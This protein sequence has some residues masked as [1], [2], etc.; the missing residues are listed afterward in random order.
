[1][2]APISLA[3]PDPSDDE[4]TQK[5][6]EAM[7]PHDVFET[8]EELNHRMEVELNWKPLLINMASCSLE[9]QL[10]TKIIL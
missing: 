7:K 9:N 5:L 4:R 2:T 3:G 8:E 6:I 1:M 10:E